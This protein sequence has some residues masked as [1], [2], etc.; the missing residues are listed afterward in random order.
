M[1]VQQSEVIR[2]ILSK[3]RRRRENSKSRG[4]SRQKRKT[5]GHGTPDVYGCTVIIAAI[6]VWL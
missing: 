4:G 6:K 2:I 3:G 5:F 1:L